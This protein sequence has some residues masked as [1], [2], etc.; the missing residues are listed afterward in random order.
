[1]S[2]SGRVGFVLTNTLELLLLF[3][4]LLMKKTIFPFVIVLA[5]LCGCAHQYVVK[6]TNG[7]E[8]SA[9]SK[10]RLKGANYHYKDAQGREV[11]IAQSRVM[12][13]QPE[14]MAA[15]DKKLQQEKLKY[16]E[17][18]KHWWQFWK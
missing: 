1:M 18:K 11:V 17:H 10:P 3:L 4:K 16:K 13:I 6:L 14:S 8:L 9:P 7:T 12:E 15:E 5:S 2:N